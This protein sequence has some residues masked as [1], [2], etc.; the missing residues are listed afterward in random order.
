M[1]KVDTDQGLGPGSEDR[2]RE[3]LGMKENPKDAETQPGAGK[4]ERKTDTVDDLLG[5][6]G[7]SRPDLPRIL[8][9]AD[10][11]PPPEPVKK[12]LTPTAPGRRQRTRRIILVTAVSFIAVIGIG[13]ALVKLG[14][15]T[16]RVSTSP[17]QT[18]TTTTI[19]TAPQTA[20]AQATGTIAPITTMAVESLPSV[21]S[22]TFAP[23]PSTT[24]SVHSATTAT[25]PATATNT[26][27][28]PTGSAP[29]GMNLLPDDPHR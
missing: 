7:T 6:F 1:G 21:K 4:V 16:A 28:H 12:E 11:T 29:P 14:Q 10:T 23:P 15:S 2:R 26:S 24:K 25:A 3:M 5:G 19:A 8:P 20:T 13:A 9:K 18:S 22:S 17:T 27:P